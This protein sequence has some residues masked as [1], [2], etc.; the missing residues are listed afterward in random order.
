MTYGGFVKVW[1]GSDWQWRTAKVWNGATWDDRPVYWK[2]TSAWK[3]AWSDTVGLVPAYTFR[4]NNW[5]TTGSNIG[6]VVTVGI[7]NNEGSWTQVAAAANIT[8]NIYDWRFWTHTGSAAATNRNMLLDIGIDTAGGTNYTAIV[9]NLAMGG[10][11]GSSNSGR[12]FRF[13]RYIPAGSSIAARI[14]CADSVLGNSPRIIFDAIGGANPAAG[15]PYG[16]FT[17][18]VG[19]ITNSA[20]VSFTPGDGAWGS[21]VELGTTASDLWHFQLGVQN[22]ETVVTGGNYYFQLAWSPAGN[23][24]NKQII[25]GTAYVFMTASEAWQ[26]STDTNSEAP[27]Y[28]V[29]AGSKLW[30]RGAASTAATT[31]GFNAVAIGTGG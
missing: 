31:A 23:D 15:V 30:V 6:T 28:P 3:A 16:T 5:G 25:N 21:Y 14:Q 19:T 26:D 18:T 10:T 24:S 27:Y 12:R 2:D 7:N 4:Y 13:P 11:N 1:D 22:S 29:V 9:T 17:E 20:G 8:Q